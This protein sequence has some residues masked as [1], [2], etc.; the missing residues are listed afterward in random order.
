MNIKVKRGTDII[1]NWVLNT[2]S[3]MTLISRSKAKMTDNWVST[4]SQPWHLQLR[5][6][7]ELKMGS[8]MAT[9]K[10]TR[11]STL[12]HYTK[13]LLQVH[14]QGTPLTKQATSCFMIP[15]LFRMDILAATPSAMLATMHRVWN[16]AKVQ[17]LYKLHP[18]HEFK[19]C[20]AFPAAAPMSPQTTAWGCCC[21]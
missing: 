3:I 2:H 9:Q 8:N 7:R 21:Y 1:H 19:L 10:L 15:S 18:H 6:R 20:A 4:P 11:N 13:Q 16:Q 17:L 5:S 12:S 14:V